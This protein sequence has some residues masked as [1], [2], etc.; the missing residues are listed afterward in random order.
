MAGASSGAIALR[1]IAQKSIP[2]SASKVEA[3]QRVLSLHRD[4]VRN[5]PWIK[6]TY[7]VPMPESVS[8][9]S[10]GSQYATLLPCVP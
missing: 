10:T 1:N 4:F 5:V 9:L 6:R 3:R 2:F 7:K 8:T